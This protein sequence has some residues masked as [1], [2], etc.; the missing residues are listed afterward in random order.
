MDKNIILGLFRNFW[1][2]YSGWNSRRLPELLRR[3]NPQK[4]FLAR[5]IKNLAL[6]AWPSFLKS[7]LFSHF[8][9]FVLLSVLVLGTNHENNDRED[10]NLEV[11]TVK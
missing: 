2:K 9:F 6:F 7:N 5:V 10:N 4:T 3:V 8:Y 11:K 1:K